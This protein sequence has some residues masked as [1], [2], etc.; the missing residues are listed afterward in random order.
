MYTFDKSN[1]PD[2]DVVTEWS[3]TAKTRPNAALVYG[4]RGFVFRMIRIVTGSQPN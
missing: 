1:Y 4:M 3:S 2:L